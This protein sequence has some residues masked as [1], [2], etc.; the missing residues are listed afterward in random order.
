MILDLG[1]LSLSDRAGALFLDR[2]VADSHLVGD[3]LDAVVAGL[4]DKLLL[5]SYFALV[6]AAFF[7]CV[8]AVRIQDP[9]FSVVGKV[10]GQD[11]VY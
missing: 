9:G 3:G 10:S 6:F 5:G 1:L 8:A 7:A 4:L 2:I 11:V